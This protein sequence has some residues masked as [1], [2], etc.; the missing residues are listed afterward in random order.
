MEKE[1]IL[2]YDFCTK[3][4][5]AML[6][7][8]VITNLA[9]LTLAFLILFSSVRSNYGGLT[10]ASIARALW[11]QTK[12]EYR[13][14]RLNRFLDNKY[15]DANSLAEG[16]ISMVMAG[17]NEPYAV[18]I[19]DQT[20]KGD[21]QIM[22]GGVP[23][24]GRCIALAWRTFEYP[25]PLKN[26]SQNYMENI[27][28]TWIQEAFPKE[29]KPLFIMDRGYAR[30]SLISAL[31]K[32]KHPFIIRSPKKVMVEV[33]IKGKRKKLLLD[34]LPYKM[35]KP[36]LYKNALY[37]SKKKEKV[38]IIIYHDPSYKQPWFLIAS[39]ECK[40]T[41]SPEE[42]VALYRQRMRIEQGFR[43]W[44]THLGLRGLNLQVRKAESILR[45]LM[46]F[47]LAYLIAM[48]LG[49][50]SWAQSLRSYME[51]SRNVPRNNTIRILSVLTLAL[52]L[53]AHP[54]FTNDAWKTII[55]IIK[56]LNKGYG[57]LYA[58]GPPIDA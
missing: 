16:M 24:E 12:F 51:E 11:M 23:Y 43:D 42:V 8:T 33:T 19:I 17:Y 25:L 26:V 5:G 44:K 1:F 54:A 18:V 21:V 45:L 41:L 9:H 2:I 4:F 28:I 10:L 58:C 13:Y 57:L 48:M 55:A 36:C 27:L 20:S 35:G 40:I 38:N 56:N 49:N 46:G 37:H 22:M 32:I 14:K 47:S 52:S 31:N 29:I 6:R 30:V 50:S 53:L 15:F 3:H 34:R 7:R 39:S